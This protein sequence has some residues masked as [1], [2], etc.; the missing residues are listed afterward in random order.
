MTLV[1][2]AFYLVGLTDLL[3][4]FNTDGECISLYT[5]WHSGNVIDQINKVA[6]T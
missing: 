4:V 2:F 3:S 6:F 5:A 1:L